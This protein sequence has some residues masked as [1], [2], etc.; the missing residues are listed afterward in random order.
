MKPKYISVPKI[1]RTTR[2]LVLGLALVYIVFITA[3]LVKI[4]AL[5][6]I[7]Y[8]YYLPV[9]QK[10]IFLTAG[11]LVFLPAVNGA[12]FSLIQKPGG[13]IAGLLL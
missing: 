11:G 8:L 1:S 9:W 2:Q 10:L 12:A 4:E 13:Y 7:N 5:W 3:S 6:G